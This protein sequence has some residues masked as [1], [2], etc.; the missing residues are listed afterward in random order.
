[1]DKRIGEL[2]SLKRLIHSFTQHEGRRHSYEQEGGHV[3]SQGYK[4]FAVGMEVQAE[5]VP[6]LIGKNLQDKLNAA[7]EE[8]ARQQAALFYNRLT[9]ATS[10]VGNAVN[11]HGEPISQDLFL[12]LLERREVNFDREGRP[13]GVMVSTPEMAEVLMK[14]L[15]EWNEDSE[16]R[17]RH[18]EIIKR[19]YE[20]W[21]DRESNRKLVD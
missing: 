1:M 13:E 2:W 18:E 3:I 6:N 16:F 15:V 10:S 21:R 14:R 19:K 11:A 7:A 5:E 9:E 4:K 20:E 8:M 12:E 17:R